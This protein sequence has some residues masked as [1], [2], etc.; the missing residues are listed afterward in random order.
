MG[1]VVRPFLLFPSL[2]S[3]IDRYVIQREIT[4]MCAWDLVFI[5]PIYGI[6]YPPQNPILGRE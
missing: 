2:P 1:C 6:K 5:A 4:H 3:Q